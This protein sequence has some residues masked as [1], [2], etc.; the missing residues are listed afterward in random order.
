MRR[1]ANPYPAPPRRMLACT[2]QVHRIGQGDQDLLVTCRTMIPPSWDT[3]AQHVW[4]LCVGTVNNWRELGPD[5][6]GYF[7]ASHVWQD[8]A[9]TSRRMYAQTHSSFCFSLYRLRP[10]LFSA[11]AHPIASSH[12]LRCDTVLFCSFFSSV[13]LRAKGINQMHRG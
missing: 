13:Y 6:F 3:Q 12:G 8:Q 1:H 5:N 7:G 11:R 2:G 10:V 4:L 9:T